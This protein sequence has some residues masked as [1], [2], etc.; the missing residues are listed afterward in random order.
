MINKYDVKIQG[1]DKLS[2]NFIVR[3]FACKDG[4]PEVLICDRLIYVL[5]SIRDEFNKPVKIVSGYRTPAYNSMCGGAPKSQH[6]KGTACDISVA[7][8]SN[9]QIVNFVKKKLN[10]VS[11]GWYDNWVHIDTRNA[12]GEPTQNWC[13]IK[14]EKE[15]KIAVKLCID[16][17]K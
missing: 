2:N 13:E 16:N 7:G 14:G 10:W 15:L 11:V 5:Q 9:F 8:V 3:E 6:I 4:T 1:N 12:Y 17:I